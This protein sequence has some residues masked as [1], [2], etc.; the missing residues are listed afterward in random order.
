MTNVLYIDSIFL[1]NFVMDLFLLTLTAVTLKKTATFTRILTGSLVG[2]IGYCL[3]LVLPKISYPVKVMLGMIPITVGMLKIS[4]KVKGVKQLGHGMGCL[5][6]YSFLFG[7]FLLF[8]R[9]NVPHFRDKELSIWFIL[10]FGYLGFQMTVWGIHSYKKKA[11]NHFCKVEIEGD[12]KPITVWGLVDTGNGLK[13][14]VTGKEVAV[15]EEEVW[16]EMTWARRAEKY[17]VIPFH[18]IG[19]SCGILEGYEVDRILI[20]TKSETRELKKIPVAVYKGKLSAKG[21][22]QM[23]LPP[24][25]LS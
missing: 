11:Q 6:T 3:V 5:F 2:A 18:S 14:P 8:L 25:W 1:I 10:L 9:N 20:Q 13:D 16:K 24:I 23:I 21:D 22:Y 4:C 15:L 12:D 17:K 19:T 7:G